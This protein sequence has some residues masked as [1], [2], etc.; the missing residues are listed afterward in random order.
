MEVEPRFRS[1]VKSAKGRARPDE[2]L[3]EWC[4]AQIPGVCKGRAECRHHKLRRGR[5]GSDDASNTADL[6]DVNGCHW[7]IHHNIE[8]A[9]ANGWLVRGAA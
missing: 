2:P 7:F 4:E 3:A 5:G 1:G 6:C 9:Y 8:W